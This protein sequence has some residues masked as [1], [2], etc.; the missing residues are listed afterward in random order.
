M[1]NSKRDLRRSPYPRLEFIMPIP[2]QTSVGK[3]QLQRDPSEMF[4]GERYQFPYVHSRPNE[5]FSL[6]YYIFPIRMI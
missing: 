2:E 4:R 3:I 1:K 5:S 6:C